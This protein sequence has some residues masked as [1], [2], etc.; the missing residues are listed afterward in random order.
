MVTDTTAVV[1]G[2]ASGIGREICRAFGEAGANVVV[3]DLR[4]EPFADAPSVGELFEEFEG[5]ALYVETDVTD[6]SS[7]EAMFETAEDRFGSVETLVNNA[8]IA[9]FGSVT[10]TS[11]EDWQAELAVN[12][13]GIFHCCKHGIPVL[14]ENESAAIINIS[15]AYGI[16]GG[17]GNFGYST[18]KGG[19]VAATKQVATEYARDGVRTNAVVPGFIDTRMFEE[20][21]P[22][23]TEEFAIKHTPQRRLGEASEVASTVRFLASEDASFVNGQ[24]LAVDGGFTNT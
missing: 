20:D 18:T 21:T 16:R 2:G 13:T 7:V 3:A 14:E 11:A 6:E 1:T 19:V 24:I 12:L 5:E 8:G 10:E 22:E 9:R 23:G 17:I 15:S 4:E